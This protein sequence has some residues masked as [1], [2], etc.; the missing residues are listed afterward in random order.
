MSGARSTAWGKA[1]V[2][3]CD[4]MLKAWP[5]LNVNVGLDEDALINTAPSVTLT[6]AGEVPEEPFRGPG[7]NAKT[8]WMRAVRLKVEVWGGT[9]EETDAIYEDMLLAL[10]AAHHG[11]FGVPGKFTPQVGSETDGHYGGKITGE[12]TVRFFVSRRAPRTA[13]ALTTQAGI[14]VQ[15]P[16]GTVT[17]IAVTE[18]GAASGP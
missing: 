11:R 13:Q 10:D 4:E 16:D 8:P 17:E 3:I 2:K 7:T 6:H 1:A 14:G 5:N 15:S 12:I 18:T 9:L